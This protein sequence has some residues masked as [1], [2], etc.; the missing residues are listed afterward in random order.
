MENKPINLKATI[1][2][3]IIIKDSSSKAEII[4]K[5]AFLLVLNLIFFLSTV[6][7]LQNIS[8]ISLEIKKGRSL[9]TNV[10]EINNKFVEADLESHKTDAEKLKILF[11][12][13]TQLINFVREIDTLKKEG[14]ITSFSFASDNAVKDK[15][16]FVGLPVVIEF[17][18]S[19]VKVDEALNKIQSLPIMLRAITTELRRLPENIVTLK[20]GGF[21]YVDEKFNQN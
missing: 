5:V 20:Y 16:G 13:D 4:R 10:A 6:I 15:T 21:L 1:N 2:R 19:L 9:K 8:N 17:K 3:P 14:V 7:L 11:P 18:G 12:D